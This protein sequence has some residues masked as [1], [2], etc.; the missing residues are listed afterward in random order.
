MRILHGHLP[1]SL[2]GVKLPAL[3]R[4][5]SY[6]EIV[7]ASQAAALHFVSRTH[8]LKLTGERKSPLADVAGQTSFLRK[9]DMMDY[10]AKKITLASAFFENQ[11][12]DTD[13]PGL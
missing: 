12:E 10:K 1:T 13:P 5:S 11:T 8:V 7:S 9:S 4:D 2:P 6:H 3:R